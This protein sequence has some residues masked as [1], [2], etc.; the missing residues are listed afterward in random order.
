M[1]AL[2]NR[3]R[4]LEEEIAQLMKQWPRHSA[5][6]GLLLRLEELEE[7]LAEARAA[8]RQEDER[9]A[10]SSEATG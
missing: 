4:A 9:A 1:D 5:P 3:V 7:A 10:P 6:P 8:L 2:K